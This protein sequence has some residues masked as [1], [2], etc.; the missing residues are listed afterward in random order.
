MAVIRTPHCRL[1]GVVPPDVLDG[2]DPGWVTHQDLDRLYGSGG[3]RH[4]R[5]SADTSRGERP[6]PDEQSS[7][8][9]R[10][11]GHPSLHHVV[12][13][14]DLDPRIFITIGSFPHRF[15]QDGTTLPLQAV[16]KR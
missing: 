3:Q 5:R 12:P 6:E 14:L 11:G 8:D 15:V 16:K 10:L 4:H 13:F 9:E 1:T 2:L 7:D